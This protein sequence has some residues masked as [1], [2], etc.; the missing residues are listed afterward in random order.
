MVWS[1]PPLSTLSRCEQTWIDGR[2][3]FDRDE[4]QAMRVEQRAMKE[5]LVQKALAGG[6]GEG[7]S[8]GRRGW[9][10]HDQAD[11]HDD[12]AWDE[13]ALDADAHSCTA[14]VR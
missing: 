3:Y 11:G 14:G 4:D 5:A 12:E 6:G 8:G 9:P 1:G 7:G 2:R 10:R 13:G